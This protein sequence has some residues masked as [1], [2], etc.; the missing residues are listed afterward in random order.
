MNVLRKNGKGGSGNFPA[1]PP[2]FLMPA[3][4]PA[5]VTCTKLAHFIESRAILA[6]LS[7]TQT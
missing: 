7:I 3:G 1:H 2:L 6:E 4:M 5:I